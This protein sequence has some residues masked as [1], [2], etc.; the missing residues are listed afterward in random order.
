MRGNHVCKFVLW[1]N[2]EDIIGPNF[3][4]VSVHIYGKHIRKTRTYPCLSSFILSLYFS[5]LD[6]DLSL[7]LLLLLSFC[8]LLLVLKN[9][10]EICSGEPMVTYGASCF[11][12]KKERIIYYL[13]LSLFTIQ[14]SFSL[15]NLSLSINHIILITHHYHY[16]LFSLEM[17]I[18]IWFIRTMCI[19]DSDACD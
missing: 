12:H 3:F 4:F 1:E 2:K 16:L 15:F 13:L 9:A 17:V 14:Y 8:F 6:I 11:A 5:C 18:Q 19:W 10:H 7:S